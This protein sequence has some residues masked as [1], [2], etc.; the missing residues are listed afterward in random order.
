MNS[1]YQYVSINQ[2]NI[3][4]HSS[5]FANGSEKIKRVLK[6]ITDTL[7]NYSSI[8]N[9]FSDASA[10]SI[11]LKVKTTQFSNSYA[12][13]Y[14]PVWLFLTYSLW[15]FSYVPLFQIL[16]CS[17]FNNYYSVICLFTNTYVGDWKQSEINNYLHWAVTIS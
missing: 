17:S 7:R 5:K 16:I 4:N 2:D 6:W 10:W 1:K 12:S 13:N 15:K 11:I 9:S 3:S 8:V 14:L